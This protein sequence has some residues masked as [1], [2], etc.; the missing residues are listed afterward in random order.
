MEYTLSNTKSGGRII[1]EIYRKRE[2][3]WVFAWRDLK[4]KYRQTAIGFAWVVLQPLIMMSVFTAIFSTRIDVS[5]DMPYPVFV[6]A[7]LIIY[8]IFSNCVSAGSNSLVDHAHILKK[9]YFPRIILPASVIIIAAVDFAASLLIFIGLLLITGTDIHVFHFLLYSAAA[10]AAAAVPALGFGFL[11]S[12]LNVRYRDVRFIFPFFLQIMLFVSPII[13]PLESVSNQL[14]KK[15]LMFNP[16]SAAIEFQ[17]AAIK[18]DI[19]FDSMLLTASLGS[20]ML[21]LTIGII[22]FY[23]MEKIF[24]DVI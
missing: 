11:F 18:P 6:F 2:L 4:V 13:Y 16:L 12:S 1:A 17:K 8:N 24:A 5:T 23:K 3:F 14:L 9:T 21:V 7:G 15:V 19:Q 22:V 10:F 20:G